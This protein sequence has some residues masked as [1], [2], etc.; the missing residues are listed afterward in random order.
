MATLV[1]GAAG[2]IGFHVCVELMTRGETVVGLDSLNAYYSV[3]LKQARLDMLSA[4]KRFQFVHV[5]LADENRFVS[6]LEELPKIRR[7]VHLAAQAGVRYS[8]TNPRSYTSS[9]VDGF[10]SILEYAKNLKNLE[11][12]VYSSSSSVYGN[13]EELPVSTRQ[14]S[15]EPESI[16][17]A[18][19]KA[20]ELLATCYSKLYGIP[21]TGLRYFTVYGPWGR[22]DMAIFKFTKAMLEGSPV[23]INNGGDMSRDFTFVDDIVDGTL[24]ALDNIPKNASR[25]AIY[26]LGRGRSEPLLRLVEIIERSLGVVAKKEFREMQQGDVKTTFAD[27]EEART[28]L[29][30]NPKIG[31]EE[32]VPIFVDWYKKYYGS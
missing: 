16:Y 8:I 11:H 12:L 20:G 15:H 13:T 25:R 18:T 1:T 17:A 32:G 3:S 23:K 30:F 28:E 31:I 19:K 21:T 27:I 5:D 14:E 29:G 6:K 22:P 7:I 10:L 2:F 26:N 4:N 9:N 24:A